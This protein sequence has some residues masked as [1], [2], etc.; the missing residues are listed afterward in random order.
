MPS[1]SQPPHSTSTSHPSEPPQT[2]LDSSHT[3]L[4]PH[5]LQGH[6]AGAPWSSVRLLPLK[7]LI[8]I[9]MMIFFF[10]FWRILVALGLLL[11]AIP[12]WELANKE[13]NDRVRVGWWELHPPWEWQP[14]GIAP[15]I[16]CGEL[17]APGH[18]LLCSRS[19]TGFPWR[20]KDTKPTETTFP[21]E[22]AAE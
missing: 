19:I 5:P 13:G 3:S 15:S 11:K 1:R 14:E 2:T 7:E 10:C 6:R 9:Q 20:D 17:M 18:E 8:L 12:Q 4:I 22:L 16:W 21:A